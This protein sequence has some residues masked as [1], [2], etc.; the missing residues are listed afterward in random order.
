MEQL[1]HFLRQVLR[2]ELSLLSTSEVPVSTNRSRQLSSSI[3]EVSTALGDSLEGSKR[4]GVVSAH[5]SSYSALLARKSIF[6]HLK[7]LLS[8]A[9]I[10]EDVNFAYRECKNICMVV[11]DFNVNHSLRSHPQG[12]GRR[13]L[14]YFSANR[15]LGRNKLN[16]FNKINYGDIME[17]FIRTRSNVITSALMRDC[18]AESTLRLAESENSFIMAFIGIVAAFSRTLDSHNNNFSSSFYDDVYSSKLS[19]P[20]SGWKSF[21]LTGQAAS[22]L[23]PLWKSTFR[24]LWSLVAGNLSSYG[25]SL[26]HTGQTLEKFRSVLASTWCHLGKVSSAYTNGLL[27]VH[28]ERGLTRQLP[29]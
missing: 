9:A 17:V 26:L 28:K 29:E 12:H 2:E 11:R 27:L 23:K 1:L 8:S 15:Y 19:L 7:L 14:Q 6:T 4:L 5:N 3:L 24:R 22:E 18:C 25:C 10:M 16:V 13:S 21:V 20:T